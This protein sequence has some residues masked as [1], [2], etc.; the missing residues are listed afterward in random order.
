MD[1]VNDDDI[2][3]AQKRVGTEALEQHSIRHLDNDRCR[4]HDAD[5]AHLE[6]D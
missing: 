2:G 5:A 4:S 6:A 3:L 1:L